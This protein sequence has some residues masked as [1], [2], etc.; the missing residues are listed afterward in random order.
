LGLF[1]TLL[2]QPRRGFLHDTQIGVFVHVDRSLEESQLALCVNVR[3]KV[4]AA[5]IF[6]AREQPILLFT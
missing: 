6:L 3:K 1:V 5:R 2:P 4:G